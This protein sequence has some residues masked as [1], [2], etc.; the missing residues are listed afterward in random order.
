MAIEH[1]PHF[2]R[3]VVIVAG[4]LDFAIT[5]LRDFRQLAL[6]VVLHHTADGI[7]LQPDFVD[8]VV[9]RGPGELA[10]QNGRGRHRT[11]KLSSVH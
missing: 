8:L 6:K 3:S 4:E 9:T 10:G 11:Q 2:L 5:D 7:E 1:G